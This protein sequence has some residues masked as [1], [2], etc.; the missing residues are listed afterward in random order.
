MCGVAFICTWVAWWVLAKLFKEYT[1]SGWMDVFMNVYSITV[2]GSTNYI[3]SRYAFIAY[4]IYAI[5]IQTAFTSNLVQ[6]LTIPQYG[7]HI[8][9]L[10]ELANSDLS[11]LVKNDL[12]NWLDAIET[13]S[14]LHKT[15][16]KKLIVLQR[17]E[18][19]SFVLGKT[20]NNYSVLLTRDNFNFHKRYEGVK[21]QHFVDNTFSGNV[22]YVFQEYST[23]N[24]WPAFSKIIE[25][26]IEFGFEDYCNEIFRRSYRTPSN[27]AKVDTPI[28]MGHVSSIFVIWSVCLVLAFCCPGSN[29]NMLKVFVAFVTTYK[30]VAGLNLETNYDAAI[31]NCLANTVKNIFDEEKTLL[32]LADGDGHYAFPDNISNPYAIAHMDVLND[33]NHY[34]AMFSN[35]QNIVAHAELDKIG[36]LLRILKKWSQK[37]TL[38]YVMYHN[39]IEDIKTFFMWFWRSKIY[40]VVIIG[41]DIHYNPTLYYS[42]Q[43]ATANQCG[44]KFQHFVIG[45]CNSTQRYQFPRVFKKYPHCNVMNGRPEL[46][47]LY[48]N[49][50]V[51]HITRSLLLTAVTVL[52]AS[53]S[54][55][56]SS[57]L[58]VY[59][60]DAI[61]AYKVGPSTI[62]IYYDDIIWS[63]PLAKLTPP[64]EILK[65]VFKPLVWLVVVI[66]FI[67]TAIAWWFFAILTKQNNNSAGFLEV[68][69]DVYSITILRSVERAPVNR[70]LRFVFIAY[71]EPR[72]Q[73]LEELANSRFSILIN[74]DLSYWIHSVDTKILLHETIYNKFIV[75]DKFEFDSLLSQR[76]LDNYGVFW[77]RDNFNYYKSTM[78]VQCH[79]F[80]DNSFS[81]SVKYVFHENSTCCP[82]SNENMLNVFVAFVMTYKIVAGLNLAT[83]Y[84]AAI[85]NCLVNTVQNIFDEEKTLL[86]LADRDGH[87][88]FPDNIS[89]PYAIAHMDVL[90]DANHYAAMF[91]NDQN[92]VAH[93][94]LRKI[95]NL[96][97]ILTK[98]SQK[99]TLLYVMYHNNIEN[100]KTF[101]MW[102]WTSKIY[103]V[104]I[105]GY[106]IHYHPTLYYSDQFATA[107]ECGEKFQHFVIGDCN[108]TEKYQFPRVLKK[109]PHCNIVDGRPDL[110][111]FYNKFNFVYTAQLLFKMAVYLLNASSNVERSS[112]L[113]VYSSDIVRAYQSAPVTIPI[114]YDDIVWSV[115]LAKLRP[116]IAILKIVFKPMMWLVVA[117]AFIFTVITWWFLAKLT[118]LNNNRFLDVLFDVYSIT[119]LGS[120]ENVPNSST[121]RYVFI[122]Y[123]IYAIHIQTA[124]TSN[125]IQIFTIP[126]YE[127]HIQNL[128][129]LASSNY[130]ILIRGDLS[131]CFVM[132]YKIVAGLNLET[133]Y[134]PAIKNCV[135]NTIKNIFDEE[136]TLLF[137]ADRDGN[138]AFPDNISNPYAIAHMDVLKDAN[139]YATML[140]NDQNIV[141]HVVQLYKIVSL[142]NILKRRS[143]KNTILFVMHCKD[144]E[145]VKKMF[146][147]LWTYKV[148]NVVII[149]YN[150]HY[151]PALYYSDQ[152]ATANQC[153]EKFQHFVIGDCN[154]TEKYQ[155][156]RVLKK[157][158]HCNIVDGR[159]DLKTF[160]NKFNFAYTAQLLFKM[161]VYLL[162][163]S[164]NVERSSHLVVYSTDIV[165]AYQSAPVTIPIYYDDIVWSVPLAKLRPLIA[166][167]KIVFK[168][169]MWLVVALAFIFTVIAW[170]FLAKLTKLNNNRF[171]DVLFDVYSITMLGSVENVPNGST[172][173]Y[174]FIAYVIY[175]IHIQTAFTS[176]LIQIF[177][178]PQYE[179]HIQ[180]LQDLASSNYSIL[181]R[182]DISHCMNSVDTKNPLHQKIYNKLIALDTM[183]FDKRVLYRTLHN[184]S[185]VW[186]RDNFNFY[187][188]HKNVRCHHFVDN[189]FSGSFKYVFYE[190]STAC[191]WPAFKKVIT[192]L[193]ETGFLERCNQVFARVYRSYLSVEENNIALSIAH[194]SSVFVICGVGLFCAFIIFQL[195]LLIKAK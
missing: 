132:S 158:P 35:D 124:F 167:L 29:E 58:T 27:L 151:H 75:L 70:A 64:F 185:A 6:I 21:Y 166:I 100:I 134:G 78:N 117:L 74:K 188:S 112:H 16:Y 12:N 187:K 32:F 44:E 80:V 139:H 141:A 150:I 77:S 174:V 155:F 138:Y 22:K 176:N 103:N 65:I 28:S 81:G 128:Q 56:R 120:V 47:K 96:L 182:G 186:V 53:T 24:L 15:I 191:L 97:R 105:I 25:L 46:N 126:Q 84:D 127:P 26:L 45:D 144:I 66:A 160:Y 31:K 135:A 37:N 171:L 89:N 54:V 39:N 142:L 193:T 38:L 106:D 173:R 184:Y 42:D 181:I 34:A 71:Y 62:P 49:Y 4:V 67:S 107:N 177:T 59:V 13:K 115:P 7:P 148:Y 90:N 153:G 1:N 164:S 111:I 86:F 69:F 152:F 180:N 110:T 194:L 52:N 146:M 140:S 101:F 55:E 83:N 162:N 170:W 161:S 129:D 61:N 98:W 41:Y 179:P 168:P 88:A 192:L 165:R 33:A 43:F 143:P 19:E 60:R 147:W 183:E 131:H 94:E 113:I 157:Y 14:V 91:S 18:F 9:N 114:Y 93:V 5:H 121:L 178:I 118:K 123:V 172:L 163:A 149:G 11:I 63:V 48:N 40:N 68:L 169:M 125:L 51:A 175:A 190:H 82:G 116:L 122:A 136:K 87:Y 102:F 2:L 73:N 156:P 109:Y 72:V 133:D 104:V 189:S 108:S 30:I 76:T 145:G 159:P 57:Y 3:S 8:N 79:H 23:V 95:E 154:S 137:L 119:M 20:L 130:S 50:N 10:Q 17:D 92:I 36:S 99:S 85:K 195:E